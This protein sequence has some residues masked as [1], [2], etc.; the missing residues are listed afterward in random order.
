MPPFFAN[1]LNVIAIAQPA[2]SAKNHTTQSRHQA[3][4]ETVNDDDHIAHT[5]NTA[6]LIPIQSAD[7]PAPAPAP[8]TCN[9]HHWA[10]VEDANGEADDPSASNATA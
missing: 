1:N 9:T 7:A 8:P 5:T 2:Q 3:T 6:V 10:T 4:V